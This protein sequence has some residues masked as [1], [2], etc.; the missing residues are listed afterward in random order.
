MANWNDILKRLTER[1]GQHGHQDVLDQ[2]GRASFC[3]HKHHLFTY[4]VIPGFTER[5]IDTTGKSAESVADEI[6]KVTGV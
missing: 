3:E 4:P 1:H 6:K 5:T 2:L